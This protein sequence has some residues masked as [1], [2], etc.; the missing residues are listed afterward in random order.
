MRTIY[1]PY[2][3]EDVLSIQEVLSIFILQLPVLNGQGLLVIHT[4]L[5]YRLEIVIWYM[6]ASIKFPPMEI[7]RTEKKANRKYT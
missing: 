7:R 6:I 3:Q 1:P 5:Y 4:V 2:D